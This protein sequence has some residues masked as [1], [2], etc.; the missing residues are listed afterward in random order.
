MGALLAFATGL[1]AARFDS[2]VSVSVVVIVMFLRGLSMGLV[3]VPVQSAVYA[4]IE[5]RNL[6]DATA[7]FSTIRQLAPAVG[8]AIGS[9]VLATG[10]SRDVE[11]AANRVDSYQRAIL[12]TSLLYLV[13]AGLALFIRDD[14]AAATMVADDDAPVGA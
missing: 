6:A 8:V 14:D 4:Q 7:I 3:F 9:S 11:S 5:R 13:G 10:F 2:S 1:A 12:V